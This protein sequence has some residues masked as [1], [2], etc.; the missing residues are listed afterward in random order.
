MKQEKDNPLTEIALGIVGAA[1]VGCVYWFVL[2]C[3]NH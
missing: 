3:M 1:V 2:W